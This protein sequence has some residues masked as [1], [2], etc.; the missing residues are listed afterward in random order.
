[1]PSIDVLF[2][3]MLH[4]VVFQD[5]TG[6]ILRMNAAADRILGK[7]GDLLLGKT[8]KDLEGSTRREDGSPFP[9]EHHPAM[10]ALRTCRPQRDVV[11]RIHNPREGEDRWISVTS[12][13][14]FREGEERPHQV[15]SLIDDVTERRRIEG[16]LQT[17]DAQ[18]AAVFDS[19]VDG[20]VVATEGQAVRWNRAAAEM[21]GL[22]RED[23][24][25]GSLPGMQGLFEISDGRAVLAPGDWPLARV[26]RGETVRNLELDVRRRDRAWSRLF[27]YS[28]N[29][30]RAERGA[31]AIA[32]VQIVDLTARRK[33]DLELRQSE[34]KFRTLVE[35]AA[36]ILIVIDGARRIRFWSPG[37][38]EA[39]G[40][41][42]AEMIGRGV[43]EIRHPEDAEQAARVTADFM[44][45][46]GATLSATLRYRHKNGGW[47]VV[48]W[49][50]R[51]LLHDSV[52]QGVVINAHDVT[53]RVR[54]EQEI[55]RTQRLEALGV[56]AGGIAHDFNNLLASVFSHV[57]LALGEVPPGS[58]ASRDLDVA[59]A[60]V[61]Q[62]RELTRQLLTFAR[63]G[64][65]VRKLC[66]VEKLVR[67]VVAIAFGGSSGVR[68]EVTVAPGVAPVEADEAQLSQGIG[69][70]L[71]NARQATPEGGGITVTVAN[72]RAE[73]VVE[74]RVVD[75]GAGIPVDV[76][77]KVFDPFFT[78]K[79]RSAGLGLATAHSIVTRHGGSIAIESSPGVGTIVTLLL[80]AARVVP[81]ESPAPPPVAPVVACRVLL[82]DDDLALRRAGAR[83]LERLGYAVETAADGEEAV[84]LYA[85]ALRAGTRFDVVMMDLTV[86]GGMGGAAAIVK[87]RELDPEVKAIVCSGYSDDPIVAE[88]T[89]HGFSAALP[90]PFQATELARVVGGIAGRALTGAR[91][92]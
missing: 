40:W 45:A 6:A 51:N 43:A 88:P 4:G 77:P 1:M 89:R 65:P 44:T 82:M 20:I 90:K 32:V 13:P 80:P 66:R 27:R 31:P 36:E 55:Q 41:T 47:R 56:V 81:P 29:L 68:A 86:P 85:E 2:D 69:N 5:A 22:T 9:G 39:L 8:S 49:T 63:G 17:R 37:A 60:A 76:L 52:V 21:H 79:P 53:E 72:R 25:E 19:L 23:P 70:V 58:A 61:G 26:L 24:R 15:Y 91:R 28:G 33:D 34:T 59:I 62:G 38:T 87:L 46:P 71:I 10:V 14:L 50:A 75:Q 73:P 54:A 7:S 92:G 57:E 64:G 11:M 84:R 35:Q 78:T 16:T 83:L 74:I 48:D 42:E 18:L 30:V 3:T 67:D 12:V